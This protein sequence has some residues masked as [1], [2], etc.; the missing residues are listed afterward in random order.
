MV[1]LPPQICCDLACSVNMSW[2]STGERRS[3]VAAHVLCLSVYMTF[4]QRET[5]IVILEGSGL[6]SRHV[7]DQF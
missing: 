3:E 5:Q 4:L 1:D 7:S 6:R 2:G